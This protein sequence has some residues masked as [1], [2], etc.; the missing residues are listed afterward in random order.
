MSSDDPRARDED[1]ARRRRDE[2]AILVVV[3]LL[4]L[5]IPIVWALLEAIF[6]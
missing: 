2:N 1:R 3:F 5:T 4:P 6:R